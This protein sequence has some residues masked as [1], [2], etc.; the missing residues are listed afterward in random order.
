MTAVTNTTTGTISPVHTDPARRHDAVLLFEVTDGNPNGDPDAGNMPRVDPETMQGLVTDVAIKRK[1]RD[2]VDAAHGTEDRYKIYVQHFGYLNRERERAYTALGIK[3]NDTSKLRE[4][5]AWMCENFY[6]IRAFGGVLS[7]KEYNCGQVR[8]PVQITFARSIDQIAPLNISIARVAIE[9][10]TERPKGGARA[11]RAAASTETDGVGAAEDDP[12]AA[13]THGTLGRKALVPYGL[14]R[15]H[16]FVNPHFAKDTGFSME[17]LELFW[18]A[19]QRM[20]DADHSAARGMMSCRGLYVFS[21][22]SMFGNAA[23]HNLFDRISAVCRD[24]VE[25]P[26]KF[27]D[28]R[29]TVDDGDMP[30]GV[31]LTTLIGSGG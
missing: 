13:A 16:V 1:V 23:A 19:L 7:M 20:W 18:E 21:H 17:D 11:A 24:G 10:N 12:N 30:A 28:Y 8:G 5:R 31:T 3:K 6:D 14:Y 25:V 2:W 26:R 27:S 4:A 22:E 29:V 15:A 9:Q